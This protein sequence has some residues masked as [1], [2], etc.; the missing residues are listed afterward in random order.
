MPEPRC[1]EFFNQLS[2]YIDGELAEPFCA[3]LER[4]LA[5]CPDCQVVVDTTRK[6]VT[7]YRRFGQAELP[8]DIGKRLWQALK[9]AGLGLT[10]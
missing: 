2:E 5:G 1:R 8:Q 6:T 10:D 9:Q 3:E 7:L 4:H